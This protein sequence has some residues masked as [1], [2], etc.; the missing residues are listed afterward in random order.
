[1]AALYTLILALL[2]VGCGEE[3]P[4]TVHLDHLSE[5]AETDCRAAIDMLNDTIGAT[6]FRETGK[7]ADV[8]VR[9]AVMSDAGGDTVRR[10]WGGYNVRLDPVMEGTL[11]PCAHELVHAALDHSSLGMSHHNPEQGF[12]MFHEVSGVKLSA[13][14]LDALRD[15][16]GVDEP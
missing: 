4:H 9:Q 8:R 15:V 2:V 1:M 7:G 5:A 10:Q 16:Y 14:E 11:I 3:P 13:D 12:L 6:V